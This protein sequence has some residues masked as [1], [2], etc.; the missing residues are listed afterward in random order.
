MPKQKRPKGSRRADEKYFR[1]APGSFFYVKSIPAARAEFDAALSRIKRDT[2]FLLPGQT[3]M[4]QE[5]LLAIL[6]FWIGDLV[7]SKGL[8]GF[9][10]ELGPAFERMREAVA[11][12]I[13]AYP[14]DE[15]P[16]EEGVIRPRHRAGGADKTYP[17]N[18][19]DTTES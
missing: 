18:P 4:S 5:S 15:P 3:Q 6:C 1:K 8:R 9:E 13:E 14:M 11:L 19:A 17:R 12:D 10:K 2:D 16:T 7:T